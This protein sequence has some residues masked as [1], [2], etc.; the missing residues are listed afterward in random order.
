[1]KTKIKVERLS[2]FAQRMIQKSAGDGMTIGE[3][4]AESE[5][6]EQML[7]CLIFAAPFLL[8]VPLPGL[9][10]ISG[11]VIF[12]AAIQVAL[13][14][15]LWLP[16]K[17]RQRRLS[18]KIL[19]KTFTSLKWFLARFELVIKPRLVVLAKHS[20]AIRINGLILTALSILLA[21]PM[22][23]GFNAPPALAIIALAIGDLEEDGVVILIGWVLSLLNVI[24]FGAFFVLGIEGL[25][26]IMRW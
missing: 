25:Q 6:K 19:E 15:D 7:V 2:E 17:W 11:A 22:P 14:L 9:S 10:T 3:L 12:L 18:G 8:P 26:A 5:E 16:A 21:L 13:G 24:F 23:P 20:L 4:L 1:M